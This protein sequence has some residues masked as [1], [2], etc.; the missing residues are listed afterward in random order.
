MDTLEEANEALAESKKSLEEAQ[1]A[2]KTSE[3][4][5]ESQATQLKE[6]SES[7][8]KLSSERDTAVGEVT[9]ITAARDDLATKLA[10]SGNSAEALIAMTKERDDAVAERTT[11]VT[12]RDSLQE[13]YTNNVREGLVSKGVKADALKDKSIV[14]LQA[15]AEAV[16][17]LPAGTTVGG[18]ARGEGQGG[19]GGGSDDMTSL[20]PLEQADAELQRYKEKN[21]QA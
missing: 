10:E 13:N 8:S 21:G 4:T 11:A 3:E 12:E 17:S 19:G 6:Q 5:R 9:T 2:L 16:G 7:V 20:S 18:T 14:Q 15:M 1:A